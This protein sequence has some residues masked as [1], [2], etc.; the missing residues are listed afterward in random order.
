MTESLSLFQELANRTKRFH[1]IT[2]IPQWMLAKEIGMEY[3]E[4]YSASLFGKNRHSL[5]R[6]HATC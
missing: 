1:S 6:Q 4:D 3:S 5:Q 2:R